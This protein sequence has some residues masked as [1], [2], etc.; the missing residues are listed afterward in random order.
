MMVG[1]LFNGQLDKGKGKGE[2]ERGKG[3]L[4]WFLAWSSMKAVGKTYPKTY[5]R[6]FAI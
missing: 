5:K 2:R 3:R 6:G 4:F 1:A